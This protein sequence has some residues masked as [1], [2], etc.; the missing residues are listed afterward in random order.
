MKKNLKIYAVPFLYIIAIVTFGGSMYLIQRIVNT[1]KFESQEPIQYVDKEIINDQEYI[2][3]VATTA[4][5]LRPYLNS[6]VKTNK[7]FYHYEEDATNQENA[8][9]FYEN[10]YMQNSGTSYNYK[11]T[12]DVISILDGTVI[13]VTENSVLGKTIKIRHGNDLI[14]TYSSLS[15]INVKENDTILRG[16]VIGKSGSCPLYSNDYN[17]YFELN[18]QGKN[19]DP[20]K[21]YEKT[22]DE[23]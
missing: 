9:V 12:F 7:T 22:V 17:L 4:T 16:Q 10:T 13:E 21:S 23:L 8:I 19:I 3:V 6:D 1:S 20:E 14:S 5:I 11:E 15:D 18:Y 2:P